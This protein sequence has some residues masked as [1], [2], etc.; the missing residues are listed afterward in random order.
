[1]SKIELE[2]ELLI[3]VEE[4]TTDGEQDVSICAEVAGINI[5]DWLNGNN[6]NKVKITLEKIDE[7]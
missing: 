3:L 4:T 2:G 7:N 1:M 6:G 5:W